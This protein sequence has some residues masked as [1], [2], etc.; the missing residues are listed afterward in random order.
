MI[1]VAVD[2]RP[3]QGKQGSSGRRTNMVKITPT[4]AESIRSMIH[5]VVETM[6]ILLANPNLDWSVCVSGSESVPLRLELHLRE[7]TSS[8]FR[9]RGEFPW[10]RVED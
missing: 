1:R 4:E 5:Q 9:V 7:M 10:D 6:G 2:S 8:A 3:P